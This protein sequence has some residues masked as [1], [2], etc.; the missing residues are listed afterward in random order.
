MRLVFASKN[1]KGDADGLNLANFSQKLSP[2]RQKWS[3][4]RETKLASFSQE[5]SL[6]GHARRRPVKNQNLHD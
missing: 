2:Q 5:M 4:F 6:S 3:K 1:A